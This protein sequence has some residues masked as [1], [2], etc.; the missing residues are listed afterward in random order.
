[1]GPCPLPEAQSA[2]MKKLMHRTVEM[3]G[4]EFEEK[5]EAIDAEVRN[6]KAAQEDMA[7]KD[8]MA[9][10]VE[11]AIT[12]ARED[13]MKEIRQ[14]S[15]GS[16]GGPSMPTSPASTTGSARSGAA[17]PRAVALMGGLG[18]DVS[19]LEL[20]VNPVNAKKVLTAQEVP[21]CT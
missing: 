8:E 20:I 6:V 18:W 14:M 1:M 16:G 3:L 21:E 19:E 9:V 2:W 12:A 7:T 10:A 11:K 5:L 13:L 17:V 4:E 15:L